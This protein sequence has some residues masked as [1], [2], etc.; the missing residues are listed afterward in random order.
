MIVIFFVIGIFINIGHEDKGNPLIDGNKHVNPNDNMSDKNA[1]SGNKIAVDSGLAVTLGQ[2]EKQMKKKFGEPDRVDRSAYG[3]DWWIYNGDVSE[4][5][6]LGM[7]DGKV[8]S[9]Y[10]LGENVDVAPFKIGQSIDAVYSSLYVE[11]TVDI[12]DK[13]NSYRFELSEEEMNMR[14][15]IELKGIYAQLYLDKF[16]GTVSSIRF[17][18]KSTLLKQK[19]YELTYHGE[20]LQ[21][22][23]LTDKEWEDVEEGYAQQIFDIT[24]I[25]RSRSDLMP[26]LWNDSAAGAAASYSEKMMNADGSPVSESKDALEKQLKADGIEFNK[27]GQNIAANY[28]DAI[29]VMEGWLNSKGHRD[30]MLTETYTD[31]GVG[32]YKQN[33]TQNFIGK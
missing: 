9:A 12:D 31:L 13:E 29:S 23:E 2:T 7:E 28:E 5:F 10:G 26:L 18:D 24:N 32:I 8:V 1:V 15:L 25:Y 19:P 17:L 4:Y 3:Y 11:P 16:S 30:T 22:D 20:L 21:T 14:P 27:A 6:Q 33:Y